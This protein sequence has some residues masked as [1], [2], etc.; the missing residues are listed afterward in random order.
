ML[1]PYLLDTIT[2]KK[3]N[4]NKE[5]TK[6]AAP[7]RKLLRAK[8]NEINRLKSKLITMKNEVQTLKHQIESLEAIHQKIQEKK[9]EISLEPVKPDKE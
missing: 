5:T 8:D 7:H 6:A 2:P 3:N 1:S 4:N 9:K